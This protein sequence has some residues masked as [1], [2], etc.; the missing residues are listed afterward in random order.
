MTFDIDM[1]ND[2][3]ARMSECDDLL[4]KVMGKP[5][6]LTLKILFS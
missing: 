5:L 4:R 2:A 6:N 3:Y 1:I